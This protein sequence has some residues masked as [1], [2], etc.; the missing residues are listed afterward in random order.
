M[1]YSPISVK[2][3]SLVLILSIFIFNCSLFAQSATPHLTIRDSW[4]AEPNEYGECVRTVLAP[5]VIEIEKVP[6]WRY[7]GEAS[8]E[9]KTRTITHYVSRER[10]IWKLSWI[11]SRTSDRKYEVLAYC[12]KTVGEDQFEKVEVLKRPNKVSPENKE[13]FYLDR[14]FIYSPGKLEYP[15]LCKDDVTRELKD[16]MYQ[17]LVSMGYLDF[18]GEYIPNEQERDNLTRLGLEEFKREHNLPLLILDIETLKQL[19]VEY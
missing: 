10:D 17:L 1:I 11:K 19:G 3:S 15:V 8:P 14:E 6:Y 5:E 18:M 4:L 2:Y 7:I 9:I 16:S 13:Q 12:I